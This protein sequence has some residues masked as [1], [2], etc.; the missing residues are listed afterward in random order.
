MFDTTDVTL[1]HVWH[2]K[3]HETNP[4]LTTTDVDLINTTHFN[5]DTTDVTLTHV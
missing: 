2:K 5:F 4:C 1:T 3:N